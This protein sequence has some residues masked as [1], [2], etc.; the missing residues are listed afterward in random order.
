MRPSAFFPLPVKKAPGSAAWSVRPAYCQALC[1]SLDVPLYIER[2]QVGAGAI[3]AEALYRPH[4][5]PGRI[6][7]VTNPDLAVESAVAADG[8]ER[9]LLEDR[10]LPV[11]LVGIRHGAGLPRFCGA[12]PRRKTWPSRISAWAFTTPV[13][14]S[15]RA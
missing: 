4:L 12:A 8:L 5:R 9:D 13:V 3:D 10:S 15:L 7:V 11:R 2:V 14:P 6:A 1:D